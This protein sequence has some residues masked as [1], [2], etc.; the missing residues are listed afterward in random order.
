[1]KSLI[2]I[3]TLLLCF[4]V[5]AQEKKLKSNTFLR[6]YNLN[7]KKIAKG[8]LLSTTKTTLT[9]RRNKK[10]INISID[11]IGSIKTKRSVGNNILIGSSIGAGTVIL[12]STRTDESFTEGYTGI[13]TLVF[14]GLGAGIGAITSIFKNSMTFQINGDSVVWENFRNLL[15]N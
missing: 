3:L 15:P 10:P 1:M 14:S 8:K 11:S 5:N 12:L 9:L 6:I 2:I 7:G 13:G 4:S